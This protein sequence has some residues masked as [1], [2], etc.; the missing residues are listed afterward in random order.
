MLPSLC[1]F[2]QLYLKGAAQRCILWTPSFSSIYVCV[3]ICQR[4][5]TGFPTV[6]AELK[7]ELFDLTTLSLA[8]SIYS[9]DCRWISVSMEH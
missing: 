1:A 5:M 8:K 9:V 6:S 7:C 4:N 2:C 3:R